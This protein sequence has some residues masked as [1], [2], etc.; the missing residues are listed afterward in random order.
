MLQT[1]KAFINTV[2]KENYDEYFQDYV[3]DLQNKNIDRSISSI[4]S[5][6]WAVRGL[7]DVDRAISELQDQLKEMLDA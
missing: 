1:V 4:H 2:K 3:F 6:V 7:N 5:N